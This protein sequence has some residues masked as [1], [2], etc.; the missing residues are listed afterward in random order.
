MDQRRFS[1]LLG[2]VLT[3][4]IFAY[5]PGSV[6]SYD[7]QKLTRWESA[8]L[9]EINQSTLASADAT[10]PQTQVECAK[11]RY[12]LVEIQRDIHKLLSENNLLEP[13]S[14]EQTQWRGILLQGLPIGHV[15]L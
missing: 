2:P 9:T 12:S 14:G 10:P 13:Y 7:M 6:K 11:D 8:Y 1:K 15:P 5:I 3:L 4:L